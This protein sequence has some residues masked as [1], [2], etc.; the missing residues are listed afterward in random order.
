MIL[1]R[2]SDT[3]PLSF[4]PSFREPFCRPYL[5]NVMDGY[6]QMPIK[7][8]SPFGKTGMDCADYSDWSVAYRHFDNNIG[9]AAY[10]HF[11]N[12]IGAADDDSRLFTRSTRSP[13][14]STSVVTAC[15]KVLLT[16][17][18]I[19]SASLAHVTNV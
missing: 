3:Q 9:A 4:Y 5:L 10:R 6:S 12:N 11:D 15:T 1:K 7:K 13:I 2:L 17:P 19:P 16:G 14:G 18:Q 8:H